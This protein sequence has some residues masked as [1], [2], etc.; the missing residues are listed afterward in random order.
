MADAACGQARGDPRLGY[1]RIVPNS[2]TPLELERLLAAAAQ[3]PAERPL[4]ARAILDSEI[5][6]L[7][8]IDR[9]TVA[10]VAQPG[11]SMSLVTLSDN[12][13]RFTP[14]FTSEAMLEATLAARPGTDGRFLRLDSR[15][16]FQMTKGSR[17]VLNPDGPHG[18]VYMPPEVEAMLARREPGAKQTVLVGAAARMPPEL[19]KVLSRFLVQ[20]PVVRRASSE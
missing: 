14:F 6:V 10:G 4:F 3:D 13:G 19:P 11:T 7:G 12:E 15:A 16:L 20:R 18:K 8:S 17:L 9:P 1:L 2:T 5:Y